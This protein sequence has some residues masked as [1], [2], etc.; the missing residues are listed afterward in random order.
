MRY[1][2]I[3]TKFLLVCV[4]LICLM[5]ISISMTYFVLVRREK[6]RESQQRIQVAF[7]IALNA[8]ST[9]F[10]NYKKQIDAFLSE[11]SAIRGVTSFFYTRMK[12]EGASQ[13]PGAIAASYLMNVIDDL[14]KVVQ[15]VSLN[16]LMLYGPDKRLLTVYQQ[17]DQEEFVG[18][19]VTLPQQEELSCLPLQDLSLTSQMLSGTVPLPEYSLPENLSVDFEK[20]FPETSRVSWFQEG[21]RLGVRIEAPI[22]H[23]ETITGVLIGEMLYTQ[24]WIEY[25]ASLS[26]THL[27][28]IVGDQVSLGTLPALEHTEPRVIYTNDGLLS[29]DFQ[30]QRIPVTSVKFGDDEYYQGVC[31]LLNTPQHHVAILT[32]NVAQIFEK[33]AIQ[34]TLIA[35]STISIIT[36]LIAFQF[37]VLVSRKTIASIRQLVKVIGATA[38]GKLSQTAIATSRDEIGYLALKI[39]GLIS[40]LRTIHEKIRTASGSV[41]ETVEHVMHEV[42]TLTDLMGQQSR[43][44]DHTIEAV[45]CI[46]EFIDAVVNEVNRLLGVTQRMLAST[47]EMHSRGEGVAQSTKYLTEN[48]YYISGSVE[49]VRS[50][51]RRIT[52]NVESLIEAITNTEKELR[53]ISRLRI[54]VGENADQSQLLAKETMDASKQG[55]IAVDTTIE[56]II[57]L[58]DVVARFA[59]IMRT[60]NTRSEQV[61]AILDLVDEITEQTSLLSLNASIISAQAGSHGRGFAIVANEIKN[62]AARTKDSTKEIGQIITSLQQETA[63]GVQSMTDGILRADRG[64]ELIRDV[65][66]MLNSILDRATQSSQRASD[67][68]EFLRQGLPTAKML[69]GIMNRVAELASDIQAAVQKEE[70]DVEQVVTAVENIHTM[71]AQVNQA[72]IE[73][74]KVSEHVAEQMEQMLENFQSISRQTKQLQ[75]NSD[76]IIEA[77]RTIESVTETILEDANAMANHTARNLVK[78]A[79]ALQS[80]VMIFQEKS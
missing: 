38:E 14:R 80:I 49:Q 41:G 69:A 57:D 30:E 18:M 44:L 59:A 50:A 52:K 13:V 21:N 7:D 8:M 36:M 75:R 65:K 48:V 37:S 55:Q 28:L 40:Q 43:A 4:L 16:R 24:A 68:A 12:S 76:E 42:N 47:K 46:D 39:N 54:K 25:Y 45:E 6:Q 5:A 3:Q 62:L 31:A 27:N 73:Q 9:Q 20:D 63:Q 23:F 61:S 70:H 78:Q 33:R 29:S 56:A 66:E 26:H 72:N 58:K 19:C 1:T 51:A 15:I 10:I 11:S 67:T 79:E 71:S 2:S 64:V 53:Y 60:V 17:H 34:R 32:S 22:Y 35:I 77:M 74:R